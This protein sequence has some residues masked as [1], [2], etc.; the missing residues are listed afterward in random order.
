MIAP[1]PRA[2]ASADWISL[3]IK[4]RQTHHFRRE[5]RITLEDVRLGGTLLHHRRNQVNRYAGAAKYRISA[6]DLGIAH[7]Q[8]ARAARRDY[9]LS[10]AHEWYTI[11][12]VL[13]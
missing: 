5:S 11:M 3:R 10:A 6:E 4:W 1:R 2:L 8:S 9:P 12:Y 7:G 13:I